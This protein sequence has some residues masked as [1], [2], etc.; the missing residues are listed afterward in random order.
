MEQTTTITTNNV[1][2]QTSLGFNI[3]PL[4]WTQSI[5]DYDSDLAQ[6]YYFYLEILQ[7]DDDGKRELA[8][9]EPIKIKKEGA[10]V[11]R[12]YQDYGHG[13]VFSKTAT[14]HHPLQGQNSGALF[15]VQ[16]EENFKKDDES[17]KDGDSDSDEE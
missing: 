7:R 13:E 12:E 2:S 11:K 4:F 1:K 17:D 9:H 5:Q 16:E 10:I 8:N 6:K 3:R 14:G 15:W